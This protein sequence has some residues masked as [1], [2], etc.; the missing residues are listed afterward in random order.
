[1]PLWFLKVNIFI[2]SAPF[3]KPRY[4]A[5][6]DNKIQDHFFPIFLGKPPGPILNVQERYL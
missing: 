3:I 5:A 2:Q 4:E 1:M 6:V